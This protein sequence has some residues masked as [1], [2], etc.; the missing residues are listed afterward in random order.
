[1]SEKARSLFVLAVVSMLAFLSCRR[2]VP[3][4][5]GE[6]PIVVGVVAP[7]FTT[8]GEGI[9][10]GVTLAVDEINK[11]GGVSGRPLKVV[12]VNDEFS[13][14][15]ATLAYQ[16]LAGQQHAVAVLG[17]AGSDVFPVME[18]LSRYGVPVL[19]TGVSAD[20]LTEMVGQEPARYGRFFRV[21]H[22]SSELAAVTSGFLRDYLHGALGLQRFAILVEDDIWTKSMRDEWKKTIASMPGASL[23]FEDT[24]SPETTDFAA[25][26][27][28]IASSKAEYVLDASSRVPSALY[29]KRWSELKGPLI[30]AIPTGAGTRKYY[31]EVGPGGTGVC[32][33]GV[34]PAENNPL[35]ER[36]AAWHK[37]YVERFGD[38]EYTSAYSYDAV[39]ILKAALERAGKTDP[40]ALSIALAKTD[41]PGVMGRYQFEASHHPKL[42]PGFRVINMLQYQL[43]EA[44]GY[45]VIWPR[46]R[47]VAA[48]ISPVWWRGKAI[49]KR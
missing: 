39:Y 20:R 38:P 18:Q 33:V 40:A 14:A 5:A 9:R 7:F 47:A 16:S 4:G 23:V 19:G 21:M 49:L 8:P 26:F 32:T 17:F 45:R 30:G 29:L 44:D 27:R 2:P 42:G 11:A 31:E 24:F 37:A 1:M 35:T 6:G 13:P 48:F 43:P 34:I 22:R 12:E 28:R 10:H 3:S 41:Q 15:K 36:A 25:T 46:E